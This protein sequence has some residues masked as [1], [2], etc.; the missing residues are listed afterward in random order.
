MEGDGEGGKDGR[1]EDGNARDVCKR[2]RVYA[3]VCVCVCKVKS[4]HRVVSLGFRV[5]ELR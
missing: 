4:P 3:C 5:K 1:D 2:A